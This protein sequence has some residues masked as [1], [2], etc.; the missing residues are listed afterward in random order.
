MDR[1]ARAFEGTHDFAAVRSVGTN[2]RSTVRTIYYC[3]VTQEWRAA[4]IEGMCQWIFV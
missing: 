1:A 2:V 4:G 3:H